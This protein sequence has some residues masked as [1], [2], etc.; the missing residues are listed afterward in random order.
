MSTCCVCLKSFDGEDAPILMM[1]PSGTPLVLCPECTE[2]VDAIAGTPDSPERDEA[3]SRLAEIEVENPI[4]ALELSRLVNHEDA[5]L[6]TDEGWEDEEDLAAAETPAP[7][8]KGGGSS[9][10]LYL[11]LGCLGVALL[12][13]ILLKILG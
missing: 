11:G 3:V 2:I 8:V 10:Y 9:L 7:A 5:P 6:D 4:V 1:D 13:Y 12:L